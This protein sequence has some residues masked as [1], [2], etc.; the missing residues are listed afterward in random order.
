M[1]FNSAVF[2]FLFLPL[3]LIGWYFLNHRGFFR[4]ALAFLSAASL[5]FYGYFKPAYL[6]LILGSITVN[7]LVL[8]GLHRWKKGRRSLLAFGILADLMLLGYF[9]YSDFFLGGIN[10]FFHKNY[11]L[12]H[13]LLPLGISFY[14]IQQ[15]SCIIDAYRREDCDPTLLEYVAYVTF[16][17]QL[18]AGPIVLSDELIPQFRNHEL[19]RFAP[20]D[21]AEG[22]S[23]FLLGL[24]KK[25][26][27]ADVLG[28]VVDFG[29]EKIYWID[30]ASAWA[31][32]FCYILQLYFDFSGYCDMARGLGRMFRLELPENFRQPLRACSVKDFWD[33]WHMTLTRFFTRYLYI[34]L[35]GSRR[36]K[37]RT[38]VNIM[39]V[40]TVSGLWHGAAVTFVIWGALQGLGVLFDRRTFLRPR[41]NLFFRCVT[42]LFLT[43]SIMI[44]RCGNVDFMRRMVVAML[45]PK[46][47]HFLP[48]LCSCLS[49]LPEF[50]M[51]TRAAET[52]APAAL[53]VLYV[54]LL[55][56]LLLVALL[57]SQGRSAAQ[58]VLKA[59]E[60]GY[61]NRFAV[62]VA[63]VFVCVVVSL[64][65]VSSFLYFNF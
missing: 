40:F 44:F 48:E 27:I 55:G 57:L 42:F 34:P 14:T 64:N 49:D 50:Y 25:M 61:P 18:V 28:H 7:Y 56:M 38:W 31:V 4:G 47:A 29:Y 15:L 9:K 21:F 17:P 60:K 45:T 3:T 33:R 43:F 11:D 13:I 19:R 8:C 59:K 16:F 46:G 36:G 58:R 51:I 26:L 12:L 41:P 10:Y 63:V 32:A 24:G 1:Y 37:V 6:L 20:A 39:I 35:G 53:P 52:L 30:T 65:Q 22:L 62:A 54:V 23:L 5:V 2:L